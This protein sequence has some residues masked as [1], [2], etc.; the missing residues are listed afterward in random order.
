MHTSSIVSKL[1]DL[2]VRDSAASSVYLKLTVSEAA[3]A[4]L[5]HT[6]SA[7]LNEDSSYQAVERWL[8]GAGG[9]CLQQQRETCAS[10]VSHFG[11]K[12]LQVSETM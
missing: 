2:A 12:G 11:P 5:N 7:H 1:R 3:P 6:S 4:F 8:V 9:G 10:I